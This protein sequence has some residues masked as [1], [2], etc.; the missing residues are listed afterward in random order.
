VQ[1]RDIHAAIFAFLAEHGLMPAAPSAM[2]A[3]GR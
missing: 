2:P 1:E 3:G